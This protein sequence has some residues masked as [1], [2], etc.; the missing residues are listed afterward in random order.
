M[1]NPR[2]ASMATI[3]SLPGA[4]LGTSVETV[5]DAKRALFV[6]MSLLEYGQEDTAIPTGK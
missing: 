5:S 6:V 1:S 3:R 4:T 2:K